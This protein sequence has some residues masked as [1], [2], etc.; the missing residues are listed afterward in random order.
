MKDDESWLQIQD[1]PQAPAE[2]REHGTNTEVQR[3]GIRRRDELRDFV[4]SLKRA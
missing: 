3:A 1:P 2:Q 4:A